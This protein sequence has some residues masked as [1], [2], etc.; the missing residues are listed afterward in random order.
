MRVLVLMGTEAQFWAPQLKDV[1]KLGSSQW[2]ASK[3]GR[4]LGLII[5]KDKLTKQHIKNLFIAR[6]L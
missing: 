2:M 5:L 6:V 4:M 1:E 3:K